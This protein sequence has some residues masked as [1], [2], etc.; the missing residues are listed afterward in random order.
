ML[1]EN[2][3]SLLKTRM[4]ATGKPESLDHLAVSVGSTPSARHHDNTAGL[5]NLEI[6]PGNYTFFDR[7]QLWTG[8]CDE[9]DLAGRVISRVIGHY[10]DRNVIMLDAGATALTKDSSPQGG[11]CA[12]GGHPE[13]DCYKMSQEVILVRPTDP[14]AALP[15]ADFP[16]G[17]LTNLLPNHSCLSAA[18]FDKY[19]IIDD[20]SCSFSPEQIVVD[21]WVP[22][23]YFHVPMS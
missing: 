19:F 1:I 11:V 7:Q 18:C 8:A 4:E 17:T 16:L 14:E 12:I 6:H 15:F 3:L 9:A 23:K 20:P 2:F 5:Q 21:E 10:E 13:L 22:A